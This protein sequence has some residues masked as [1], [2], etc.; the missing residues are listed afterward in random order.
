MD[1]LYSQL[2]LRWYSAMRTQAQLE[3]IATAFFV[4]ALK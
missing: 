1:L 3:K 2:R 4:R